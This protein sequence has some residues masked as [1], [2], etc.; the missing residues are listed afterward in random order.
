MCSSS[1]PPR[2]TRPVIQR[3]RREYPSLFAPH[4][5]G[6]GTAVRPLDDPDDPE[7]PDD[8]DDPDD[9][10]LLDPELLDPFELGTYV[11]VGTA[12]DDPLD[13]CEYPRPFTTRPCA[14]V[15]WSHTVRVSLRA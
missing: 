6:R 12:P 13:P 5:G 11:F 1:R 3:Q 15:A 7:D 4:R 2:S 14:C 10:E 9:P 8:P